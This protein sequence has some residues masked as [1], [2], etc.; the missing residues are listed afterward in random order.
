[1]VLSPWVSQ[2]PP[3]QLHLTWET[4]AGVEGSAFLA[5]GG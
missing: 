5:S 4:M 2:E 1:M 3:M